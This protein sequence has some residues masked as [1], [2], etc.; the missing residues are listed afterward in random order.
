M[1]SPLFD[2]VI[3]LAIRVAKRGQ[4]A[5]PKV[6]APTKL[7]PFLS[8][9]NLPAKAREK[10]I[11]VVDTD[12]EF[13]QRVAEKVTEAKHGRFAY[14]Y[15][16][17]PTGWEKYIS[18]VLEVENEPVIESSSEIGKLE[19]K[20][21]AATAARAEAEA[22]V[23]ELRTKLESTAK[24]LDD[25]K[26]DYQKLSAKVSDLT[27][28]VEKLRNERQRAVSELK[29]TESVMARHIASRKRLE[30]TLGKMTSAQL[31]SASVGGAIT[32]AEVRFG[33][34]SIEETIDQLKDHIDVMRR[35][36]T[37]ERIV[38][39]RRVPLTPPLGLSDDTTEFAEYLLSVPNIV[40]YVDGYNVSKHAVPD[41]ELPEQ[42]NWLQRLLTEAAM[43]M[44]GRFEVIFDGADVAVRQANTHPQVR[45]RFSPNEVEAD[46][47][48]IE[49][50]TSAESNAA[51]VVVSSDKRVRAG[52][53]K[54]GANV[55]HSAQLIAAL[56]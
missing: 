22:D 49:A 10:V 28:E 26:L 55:L 5:K 35:A 8:F 45:I 20:L 54:A 23:K 17:R 38:V 48:I 56:S 29:T 6:P 42:R 47:V 44:T 39:A 12:D 4:K 33:L 7:V 2:P 32:D 41:L 40:V 25:T 24:E 46:D 16:A 36:S 21:R 30:D 27:G 18:A 19:D 31:S 50:V 13:R 52:A 51:V 3:E 37:P 43:M 15:L 53:T 1:T 9:A 14:T 34:D 11:E